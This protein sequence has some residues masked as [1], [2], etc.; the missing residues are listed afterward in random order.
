M[1]SA[2]E[3]HQQIESL[4][5]SLAFNGQHVFTNL[6]V[7]FQNLKNIF[8]WNSHWKKLDAIGRENSCQNGR[9]SY[10]ASAFQLGYPEQ[11]FA[12]FGGHV[13]IVRQGVLLQGF[14]HRLLRTANAFR[15]LQS[16][17]V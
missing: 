17:R 8:S 4:A 6:S 9:K 1:I 3:F 10:L 7:P 16:A 15:F 12:K 5:V 13:R 14:E 2:K 11:K